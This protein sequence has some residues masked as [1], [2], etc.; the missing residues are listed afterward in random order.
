MDIRKVSRQIARESNA[1]RPERGGIAV[2]VW[3]DGRVISAPTLQASTAIRGEDNK[4][5]PRIL[6]VDWPVSAV[7]AEELLRAALSRLK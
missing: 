3:P 5:H 4:F 1:C 6:C 2:S 7:T